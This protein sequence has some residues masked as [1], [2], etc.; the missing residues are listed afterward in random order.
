MERLDNNLGYLPDNCVFATKLQQGRNKRTTIYVTAFGDTRPITAWEGDPRC[1]VKLATLRD[2]LDR[3][4]PPEIA[5]TIPATVENRFKSTY[6]IGRRAKKTLSMRLTNILKYAAFDETKSLLEWAKDSRCK[7]SY[8]TLYRRITRSKV[9]TEAAIITPSNLNG[10]K[11]WKQLLGKIDPE[12]PVIEQLDHT[13]SSVSCCDIG[14][15]VEVTF[16]G[17][18]SSALVGKS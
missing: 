4:V 18:S 8:D 17:K 15:N 7:V 11:S 2:R 13:G 3:N 6:G 12:R 9:P 14:C 16:D 5:M 1:L 10:H